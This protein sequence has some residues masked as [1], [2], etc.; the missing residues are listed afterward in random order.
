MKIWQEPARNLE[1]IAEHDVV[2]CG[3]GPAGCAAALAAGKSRGGYF[4]GG[5]RG[6]PG[7]SHRKSTGFGDT[8]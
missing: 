8:Q 4:T 1:I 3:G 7:R 6:P 2:V 5:T